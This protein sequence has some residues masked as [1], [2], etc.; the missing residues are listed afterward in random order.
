VLLRR[1][2]HVLATQIECRIDNH[3]FVGIDC[4]RCWASWRLNHFQ[5]TSSS[6]AE[7]SP[8]SGRDHEG[9]LAAAVANSW[10]AAIQMPTKVAARIC[11]V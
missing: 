7:G 11:L 9:R 3:R 6:R 10:C 2:Y 1:T 8:F 4:R 5:S